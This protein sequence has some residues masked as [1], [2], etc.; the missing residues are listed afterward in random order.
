MFLAFLVDQAQSLTNVLFQR[1]RQER[2][3]LYSLWEA[4]RVYFQDFQ[5]KNWN[6][7]L[8]RIAG[9]SYPNSS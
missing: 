1:A 9:L 3:T 2:R 4:M 7:F 8:S 5:W 6:D